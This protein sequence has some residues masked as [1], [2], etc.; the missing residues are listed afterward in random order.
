MKIDDLTGSL[1]KEKKKLWIKGA[2]VGYIKGM[3]FGSFYYVQTKDYVY[4]AKSIKKVKEILK[5]LS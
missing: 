2:E 1:L 3:I 4:H 5:N